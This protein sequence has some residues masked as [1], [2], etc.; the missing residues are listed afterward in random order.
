MPYIPFTTYLSFVSH[1]WLSVSF[2]IALSF[3]ASCFDG[4]A[5]ALLFPILDPSALN[6][7]S[8]KIEQYFPFLQLNAEN[9]STF[10]PFS[11]FCYP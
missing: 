1:Q 4:I 5:L 3:I 6:L 2:C 10:L 7:Y 9:L 8:A 11:F